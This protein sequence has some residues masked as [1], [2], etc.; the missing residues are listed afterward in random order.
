M[1]ITLHNSTPSP[2]VLFSVDS[3][4]QQERKEGV[5]RPG[6]TNSFYVPGVVPF[7]LRIKN[8]TTEATILASGII[9][10]SR[11]NASGSWRNP[12]NPEHI[13]NYNVPGAETVTTKL[14][15]L[16]TYRSFRNPTNV[17]RTGPQKAQPAAHE[18]ILQEADF[19]LKTATDPAALEGT[20]EW[21]GGGL[22]LQGR[23]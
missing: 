10:P 11:F 14:S 3:M 7:E 9:T 12:E 20:I 21:E 1:E 4:S 17:S 15:G 22:N 13:I 18:F 2:V 16:W 8:F 23:V 5:V 6:V 19:T